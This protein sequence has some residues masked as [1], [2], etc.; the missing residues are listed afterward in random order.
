MVVRDILEWLGL[1]LG[2]TLIFLVAAGGFL[3]LIKHL[4]PA[5]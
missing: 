5:C 3:L 4:N 2:Y 1:M